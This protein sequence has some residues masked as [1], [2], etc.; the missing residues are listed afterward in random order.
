MSNH[1]SYWLGNK[2]V[3]PLGSFY[4]SLIITEK[5]N[6]YFTMDTYAGPQGLTNTTVMQCI[7]YATEAL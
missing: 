2:I 1:V 4:P 7:S 6:Q 5:P 3:F